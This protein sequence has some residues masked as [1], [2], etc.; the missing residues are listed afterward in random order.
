MNVHEVK[1]PTLGESVSEVTIAQWLVKSGDYVE[2]DQPLCE[3][4]S[5]KATVEIPSPKS[6]V[7]E[8]LSSAQEIINVGRVI[9]KINQVEKTQE[10]Q[11]LSQENNT[12]ISPA[13][14][15]AIS[16]AADKIRREHNIAREDLMGTGKEGRV[17]KADVLD[18]ISAE[19]TQI[20]ET[21][22]HHQDVSVAPLADVHDTK[23]SSRETSYQKMSAMRK[24]IAKRL[25]VAKNQTAMLTTFNE[26]NMNEVMILRKKYKDAF[27]EKYDINLGY[28]SFFTKAVCLSLEK[29]PIINAQIAGEEILYHHY[30]DISVAISTPKGLVVPIIRDAQT[31]SLSSIERSISHLAI[32]AREG[33][34]SMDEMTGGTFTITNGGV[35]GSMLSTPLLNTPQSA[36]LGMHNIIDRP[37]VIEGEIVIRPIMYVALSYDHR[38]IDGKDSVGFLKYIKELIEDPSR[39]LLDL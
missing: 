30:C 29:F 3:I 8:I 4:E 21:P 22:L 7:V 34:L 33:K 39:L 20:P 26:I 19:M 2:E 9:A 31:M 27:K 35:F 12:E 1:I 13:H 5:E 37:W 16:P 11:R 28:M 6:G 18:K 15:Q 25:L 10:Q 24:T 17:T 23:L 36:I 14:H 32:K 38:I